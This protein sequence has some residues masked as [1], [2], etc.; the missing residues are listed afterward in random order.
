MPTDEPNRQLTIT[1]AT[2]AEW[3]VVVAILE[4]AQRWLRSRD[5]QQWIEPFDRARIEPK[6][7]AGEFFIARLGH[8]PVAVVRLL[9]ADQFFWE[10]P[11]R[12]GRW[13]GAP[14]GKGD[15]GDALYIHSL[16]VRRDYSGRGLGHQLL[17]WAATEARR[18][19]RHYL[20]L[21]CSAGNP[22]LCSYYEAPASPRSAPSKSPTPP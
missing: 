6:I 9:R 21:D 8:Y 19:G 17:E 18:L 14:E 5:I 20:R 16:A 3:A 22:P 10:T 2:P 7:A 13:R 15:D 11:L 1:Q 12:R 4:D